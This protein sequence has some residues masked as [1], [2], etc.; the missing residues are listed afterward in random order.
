MKKL[1]RKNGKK[2]D[3]DD[4]LE[5][6]TIWVNDNIDF[7]NRNIMLEGEVDDFT[8]GTLIRAIKLM[9][10]D[11]DKPINF[12]LNTPG[13]SCYDGFALYD[14]LRASTCEINVIALGKIMSMG[15]ILIL[16]GDNKYAYKNTAFMWHSVSS[17]S[18][19]NVN[20]M[21]NDLKEM[22][23]LYQQII[24]IYVERGCKDDKFW[25]KWLKA[26]DRYG[27]V[28]KAKELGF[29]DSIIDAN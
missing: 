16:A 15:T 19:G 1:Q 9:E 4:T 10:K 8:V 28:E 24:D 7:E 20:A 26:E 12:Y 6:K 5:L 11:S 29:I 27:D 23:R 18:G 22:K 3:Q 17:F 2:P 25:K 13:G 21:E 14:V